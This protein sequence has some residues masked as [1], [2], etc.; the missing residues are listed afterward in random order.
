M[1]IDAAALSEVLSVLKE[2]AFFTLS[3]ECTRKQFTT[4]QWLLKRGYQPGS[5]RLLWCYA[6]KVGN[7]PEALLAFWLSNPARTELKYNEMMAKPGWV[8]DTLRKFDEV[9]VS[10]DPAPIIDIRAFRR[11]G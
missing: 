6:K 11:N 2:A 7:D 9:E 1:P 10:G 5:L 8:A 3:P 4:A